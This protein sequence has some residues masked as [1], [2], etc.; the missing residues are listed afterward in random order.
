M[1]T[2]TPCEMVT[3]YLCEHDSL[4]CIFSIVLGRN[5]R[6]LDL[7]FRIIVCIITTDNAYKWQNYRCSNVQPFART[8]SDGR[9][10]TCVHQLHARVTGVD[11]SCVHVFHENLNVY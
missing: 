4:S 2:P 9:G 6:Q 10:T 7:T 11:V 5:A 3:F 8:C 1:C